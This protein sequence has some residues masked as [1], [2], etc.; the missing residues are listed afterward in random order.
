M[1]VTNMVNFLLK[2]IFLFDKIIVYFR[3]LVCHYFK[4]FAIYFGEVFFIIKMIQVI[5]S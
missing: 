2:R 1:K 4:T 5:K 3:A